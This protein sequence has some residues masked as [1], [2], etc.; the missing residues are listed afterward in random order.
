MG[1]MRAEG[2]VEEAAVEELI[3]RRRRE[4]AK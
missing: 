4:G 3:A 2:S 1:Q